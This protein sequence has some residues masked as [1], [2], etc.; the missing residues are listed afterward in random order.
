M[1]SSWSL[2]SPVGLPPRAPGRQ[3]LHYCLMLGVLLMT[4]L[5]AGCRPKQDKSPRKEDSSGATLEILVVSDNKEQWNGSLGDTLRNFF[6]Q[7]QTTISQPEPR[8]TLAHIEVTGFSK[9]FQSHHNILILTVDSQSRKPLLETR[10][11]LW[12]EPQRVI[13]VTAPSYKDLIDEVDSNKQAFMDLFLET[14]YAR[15]TKTDKTLP[16][17]Q[18]IRQ[19]ENEYKIS[20]VIPVGYVLAK[21]TSEFIWLRKET[22]K[23]SQ[24]I[25]VYIEPYKDTLQFSNDNIIRRRNLY[26][27]NWVPGPSQGS[28]MTTDVNNTKPVFQRIMLN[29]LFAVETRGAW[30]T[31]GDYMG[32]PFVSYSMVD[33]KQNRLVTLEGYVYAPNAPKTILLHHVES[34]CRTVG[35]LD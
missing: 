34:I 27:M 18:L 23:T 5:T 6:G 7:F 3:I 12:A 19:L 15:T 26:T 24:G 9:M 8:F 35:F 4:M 33:E 20:L 14:E 11:D 29:G 1:N 22:L 25:L 13:K 21:N 32:G 30:E 2:L 28:F 31:V 10:K 17:H 16:E